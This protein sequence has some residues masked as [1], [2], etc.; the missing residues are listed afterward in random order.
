MNVSIQ[1]I[2]LNSSL[3][4]YFL[5]VVESSPY[6][7]QCGHYQWKGFP[8]GSV[9][10]LAHQQKLWTGCVPAADSAALWVALQEALPH[11]SRAHGSESWPESALAAVHG[12][13]YE[14]DPAVVLASGHVWFFLSHALPAGQYAEQEA[15][16]MATHEMKDVPLF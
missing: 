6:L 1:R 2:F 12:T 4:Y 7:P 3:D 14:R 15:R 16:D 8:V 10:P 11:Q 9:C 13:G 5:S